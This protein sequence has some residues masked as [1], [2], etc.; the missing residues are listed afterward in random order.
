MF[1]YVLVW[2]DIQ[3]LRSELGFI[4]ILVE[5]NVL[6]IELWESMR[7]AGIDLYNQTISLIIEIMFVANYY[8]WTI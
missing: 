1:V 3:V 5:Q 8:V 4:M 2:V 6:K 7:V